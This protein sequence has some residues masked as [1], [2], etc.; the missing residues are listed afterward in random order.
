MFTASPT[1]DD[2]YS[3]ALGHRDNASPLCQVRVGTTVF[4]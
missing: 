2:G 1:K 4:V 3:N